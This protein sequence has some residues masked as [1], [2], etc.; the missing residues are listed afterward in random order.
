MAVTNTII[1]YA[2]RAN[3]IAQISTLLQAMA[4]VQNVA[5]PPLI[6][7]SPADAQGRTIAFQLADNGGAG[8]TLTLAGYQSGGS[9]V[10]STIAKSIPIAN[11]AGTINFNGNDYWWQI[12]NS[13]TIWLIGGMMA[14]FGTIT[15]D[16]Y[17]FFCGGCGTSTARAWF[18]NFASVYD[19]IATDGSTQHFAVNFL[20]NINTQTRFDVR[21]GSVAGVFVIPAFAGSIYNSALSEARGLIPHAFV[22]HMSGLPVYGDTLS[23]GGVLYQNFGD[24]ITGG[25]TVGGL[26][27]QTTGS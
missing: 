7:T 27:Y 16:P 10:G 6:M 4:W 15:D 9:L 8:L 12:Y 18:N 14:A 1:T 5:G 2:N 3:L 26:F 17:P 11:S 23:V 13:N 19:M 22:G 25:V 21:R 20:T 24:I